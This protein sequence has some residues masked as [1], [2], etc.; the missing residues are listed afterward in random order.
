M[1]NRTVSIQCVIRLLE[2]IESN[3]YSLK[4][5][6]YIFGMDASEVGRLFRKAKG[7]TLKA[8]LDEKMK[9]RFGKLLSGRSM[10][11]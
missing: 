4:S 6:S 8:Y 11:G 3:D 5:I 2:S 9:A 1:S 10:Y 7:M